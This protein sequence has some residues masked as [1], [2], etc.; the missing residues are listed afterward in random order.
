MTTQ[1][2]ATKLAAFCAKGEFEKAQKELYAE[3]VVSIEPFA[4]PAFEKETKGLAAVNEKI[5]QFMS[6]VEEVFAVKVSEP[7]VAGNSFAF[8]MDMDVRM[9]GRD[10][11]TMS[12]VCVYVTKDGKVI[13]EQFF[14]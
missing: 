7:I 10:R 11:E 6:M 4:T 1:Q 9:K 13:S 2:I 14:F 8:T 5:R 12:E 3:D